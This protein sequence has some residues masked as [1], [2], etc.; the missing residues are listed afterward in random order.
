[1]LNAGELDRKIVI[2]S[3]SITRS[4]S[5]AIVESLSDF[6]TVWAKVVPL[7]A[8]ERFSSDATHAALINSFITRYISGL[9]PTMQISYDN[10][11]WRITGIL[12]MGRHE[13]HRIL[14]E[15]IE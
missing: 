7:S 13:G 10:L 15:A 5:G 9:L 12:E 6:M 4:S 8:N 14:A 11:L 1:M 2:K 3:V